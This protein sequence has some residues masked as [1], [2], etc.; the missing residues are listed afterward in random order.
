MC[1]MGWGCFVGEVWG[2]RGGGAA[3]LF[4]AD[5]GIRDDVVTGVERGLLRFVAGRD[6]HRRGLLRAREVDR[7]VNPVDRVVQDRRSVVHGE[8]VDLGGR[9]VVEQKKGD[10]GG[11][12]VT[13]KKRSGVSTSR[14]VAV[15]AG[16][17]GY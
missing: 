4:G 5:E 8:S 10:R 2:G 17:G 15:V 16:V 1:V 14:A 6:R 3:L 12:G 7:V 13:W 11:G 9:G